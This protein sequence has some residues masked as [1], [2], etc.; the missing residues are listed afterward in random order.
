MEELAGRLAETLASNEASRPETFLQLNRTFARPN[1]QATSLALIQQLAARIVNSIF[2]RQSMRRLF[3]HRIGCEWCVRER[4][5]HEI[6]DHPRA[7][8]KSAVSECCSFSRAQLSAIRRS[9]RA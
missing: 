5:K 8:C 6:M 7:R 3:L 2:V 4:L 9:S 1:Q